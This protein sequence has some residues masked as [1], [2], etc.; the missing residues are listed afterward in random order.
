MQSGTPMQWWPAVTPGASPSPLT[1]GPRANSADNDEPPNTLPFNGASPPPTPMPPLSSSSLAQ[2]HRQP[3]SVAQDDDAAY[4]AA[5]MAPLPTSS[6]L[7]P[8]ESTAAARAR[9]SSLVMT[10][11]L[12][13][14]R[15]L[16]QE[17]SGTNLSSVDMHYAA[18]PLRPTTLSD[19]VRSALSATGRPS[20]PSVSSTTTW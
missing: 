12:E 17:T 6:N 10:R 1:R 20:S 19:A 5:T 14:Q 16:R 2:L 9:R 3:V 18:S 4:T 13:R 15:A 7:D 8:S 11:S